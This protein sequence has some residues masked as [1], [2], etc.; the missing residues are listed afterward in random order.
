MTQ[1]KILL[2]DDSGTTLMMEK[3]LLKGHPWEL[4]TA[5]NGEQAIERLTQ[6]SPDLVL[7]DVIMPGMNGFET[8][9]AIRSRDVGREIPIIMVTTRGE[10][11]HVEEGFASGCTDY[12]TKPI[13]GTEL[14]AKVRS[15]LGV[16]A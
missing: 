9:R 3:M 10:E 13:N 5:S 2:V 14:V 12:V 11:Q 6:N 15:Y 4:I 7:L 8:C 1:K 16:P